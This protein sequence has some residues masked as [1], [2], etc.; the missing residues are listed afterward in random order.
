MNNQDRYQPGFRSNRG[1][2][3]FRRYPN[4]YQQR[5]PVPHNYQHPQ[6]WMRR[7]PSGPGSSSS[8]NTFQAQ[9]QAHIDFRYISWVIVIS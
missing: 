2:G 1:G 5:P 7:Y 9:A 3:N 4:Y 8:V 6:Q